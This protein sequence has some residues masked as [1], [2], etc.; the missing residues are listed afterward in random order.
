MKMKKTVYIQVM[1]LLVFYSGC[2]RIS[3]FGDT[4]VNPATTSTPVTAA[5]LTNVLSDQNLTT[6]LG[7][8]MYCQYFS[9]TQYT[10]VSVYS[11][12]QFSPMGFYSGS[13]YDLQ[14]IINT[15][16]SDATKHDAE[17]YGANSNQI[18]IAR[19]LKAYTFWM[20]TDDY[21]D[22]PYSDALK[23]DPNVTYD[24]QESIYKDLIKELTEAVSQFTTGAP[25]KGDIVYFGDITKWKKFANSLRML[26]ALNLSKRYPD[27]SDYA[28]IQF[29]AALNDPAGSI[30][31]NAD[32][33]R[34]VYP[35]G[36]KW[37]NPFF[38][39]YNGEKFYGE[40]ETLTSLL[41]DS[42]GNDGRQE[43]Y[44]ADITGA[45]STLGVPYG[46]ER[47]YID[48]WCQS[49]PTWCFILAPAYRTE[50]S[51]SCLINAASIL[52][53]RAEAADRGWT[54]ENT[55]MLYSAGITASFRQWGL[56]AP[57][58]SYFLKPK[59]ALGAAGTNVKQI[60]LQ[61]YFAYYPDGLH[62]WNTWR[63]TGWPVLSPAPD[64]INYPKVIPRRFTYGAEDYALNPDGVAAAVE[65][66]GTNGDKMDSRVWWDKE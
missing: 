15:N 9:E 54:N 34:L 24:P 41:I 23:G 22:I 47:S 16:S 8:G 44:G 40:S 46:R 63:R 50:T 18:A 4:N 42:I 66:L 13:L 30:S 33:F 1:A 19:I 62:G 51:P 26:M 6:W 43:A 10:F 14:N 12:V 28:A 64:A 31:D 53:A 58:A 35:G 29:N 17:A 52:L 57:D 20:F 27:G 60:A 7:E 56:E 2:E 45:Y 48:P 65:R 49:H 5:L 55:A 39:M 11:T 3:D 59:V 25:I 61:E 36:S 37:R 32:N 38:D 21:G